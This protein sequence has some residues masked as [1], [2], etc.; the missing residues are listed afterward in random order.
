MKRRIVIVGAGYAGTACAVRLARKSPDDEVVLVNPVPYFVERIRLHEDVAAPSVRT[1]IPL[2]PHV[3]DRVRVIVVYVEG[4]DLERRRLQVGGRAEAFDELVLATGSSAAPPRH[5]SSLTTDDQ[6]LVTRAR[7]GAPGVRRV[8][9][10]GAG[11]T[12]TEL[13]AE[14]AYRRPDLAITLVGAGDLVP[15]TR[16]FF[17]RHGVDIVEHQRVAAFERDGVILDSGAA[18]ASDVTVWAGGFV[19]SRLAAEYAPSVDDRLRSTTHPFVRVIGDAA[20]TGLRMACAVAIPTGCYVADDLAG[21]A[22]EPF[23]WRWVV[24]CVSLGRKDGVVQF[25]SSRIDGRRAAWFKEFICRFARA[26]TNEGW[27]FEYRWPHERRHPLAE[28]VRERA[29][30]SLRDRVPDAR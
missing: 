1:R 13:A 24:T 20:P 23:S 19:P 7:I 29:L 12:G 14:L 25:E 5:T 3:G 18:I 27:G 21:R 4:I 26:S 28:P 15:G 10:V 2:E 6:A 30:P 9:V 22:A 17:E 11:L 8:V 16:P